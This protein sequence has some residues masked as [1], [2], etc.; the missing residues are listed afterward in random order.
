MPLCPCA[1]MSLLIIYFIHSILCLLIT[2]PYLAPHSL[3]PLHVT[4]S[5]FF[6]SA[7]LSVLYIHL[8]FRLHL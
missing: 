1:N 5:L 6:I 4:I 8:H 3:P 2:Y 7:S